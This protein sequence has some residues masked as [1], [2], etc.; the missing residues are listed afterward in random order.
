MIINTASQ[1]D[2]DFI[3]RH[4]G[5]VSRAYRCPAGVI[6]IGY[7]FTMGSRVFAEFWREK[8]GRALRM[9]DTITRADA[10]TLLRRLINAEYG[11]AVARRVKP[12]K[13][14]HFGGASSM[15]FNCGPGA[16]GWRWAKALA[17]GNIAEAA[18]L[19]RV[20]AV[21]ANGRKLRGL[22]RRRADEAALIEHGVY[23]G[24]KA[25]IS[26][27]K[28]EV[29]WYQEQLVA[30]GAKIKVDGIAGKQTDAAVRAFQKKHELEVDGI[31]GP[32]T[33]AALIR[34]VDSSR[35]G[36]AAGGAAGAGVV[37]GGGADAAA[38]MPAADVLM[39]AAMWG[40]GAALVVGAAFLFLRYR[41]VLTGNRVAT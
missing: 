9:G 12:R 10:D 6:T 3:A 27:G 19:L 37:G 16:L 38:A 11:A 31:V 29:R 4:E 7:G 22:V 26:S 17:A 14:N 8:H 23:R 5:F 34:A 21:T 18:R 40:A 25:A 2:V 39:S 28:D 32:A 20:T 35:T 33:R 24:G 36:K 13:Q 30:L 1:D 15:T 41:G